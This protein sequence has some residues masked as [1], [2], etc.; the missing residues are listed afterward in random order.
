M[1]QDS[2]QPTAPETVSLKGEDWYDHPKWYDILHA[3]GTAAEV[4][5]V[6]TIAERF[7]G[8][9]RDDRYLNLFEP[10]CGTARHLR[11]AARRGHRCWGIDLAEPM[12]EYAR[13]RLAEAGLKATLLNL[14]MSSFTP[15][16]L[17]LGRE[18]IDVAFCFINS[19]RHLPTDEAIVAHLRSVKKT[20]STDGVYALGIGMASYGSERESEDVWKG[21]RG[22]CTVTQMVQYLPPPNLIVEK[23]GSEIDPQR[24]ERVISQ[25]AVTTP[26]R[27]V[28][29][30]HAFSLRTYNAE[31]FQRVLNKAGMEVIGLVDEF[32]DDLDWDWRSGGPG[33]GVFILQGRRERC[34]DAHG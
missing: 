30:S 18:R 20:L 1:P 12:L 2:L 14:D 19:V 26:S 34:R 10:A 24:N 6:E 3:R 8:W 21:S 25:L 4:T 31:E 13:E 5:G 32:G 33:Y 7:A 16:E 9:D 29:V 17:R 22:T 15:D 23:G 11:V 27:E 28:F